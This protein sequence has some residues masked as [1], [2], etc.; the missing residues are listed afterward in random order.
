[1]KKM[2]AYLFF[3]S[4]LFLYPWNVQAILTN[5]SSRNAIVM[6][7]PS[8]RILYA[9]AINEPRLIASITKIMTCILAIESGKTEDIVTVGEEVLEMYG[10]N[11]YLELGEQMKLKDLL[12]GLML[13]SGNDA[14]IVIATYIGGSEEQF[15]AMMNQKAQ[16]I[17]MTNTI[18]RNSHGLDEKTENYSTAYDMAKLSAYAYQ[19]PMYREITITKKYTVIGNDK[20]Y[21]WHNRNE[22]LFDYEYI[23]SGKTGY[24][25]RAG[26]TLVTTASKNGLEL[27]SVVFNDGNHYQT[28]KE[29]YEEIFASYKNYIILDKDHFQIDDTYYQDPIY[30]ENSFIYPLTEEEAENIRVLIQLTK[31]KNYKDQEV[32]GIAKV[33]LKDEVLHEEK[34]HVSI[35]KKKSFWQRIGEWFQ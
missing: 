3:V 8:G 15:V 25:P 12:Y 18:F 11:I 2:I 13:R 9:K 27:T 20:T 14:A 35:P 23:T 29:L 7:I 1:M 21:L 17:G 19:N 24:T 32:V 31:Q 4:L 6:D 5:V 30:I 28:Q 16:E 10:S 33:L 22:L 34:I 26:K